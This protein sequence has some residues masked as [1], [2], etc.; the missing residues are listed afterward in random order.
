MSAKSFPQMLK[1][2]KPFIAVIVLQFGYAGMSIIFKFALNQGI[3][4]HVLV[5]YRHAVATAVVAP[6]ALVLERKTRPK[7]TTSVFTKIML[8]GLLEPVIDQNLCYTGL[9]FTTATVSAAMSNVLP[10][11]VFILAWILRLEKVNIGRIHSQAKIL[12][13]IVTVGGAMF[14]TLYNGSMLNLPWAKPANHNDSTQATNNQSSI[15]GAVMISAGCVTWSSFIILQAITL[16]SYPAELSLTTFICLSGAIQSSVV[17]LALEWG[18]PAAWSISSS[19]MLFASLYSG[20]IC[21]GFSIYIQG[22]VMKVKGPV[23][24]TAFNPLS[25]VIVAILSSFILSEIMYLGRV[26]GALFIVL[27]LYM[28][29]WGKSKDKPP[30]DQ[31][32]NKDLAQEAQHIDTVMDEK[33]KELLSI[34]TVR[35]KS[36]D[37]AVYNN[38]N[39]V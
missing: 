16:K 12:G 32:S 18:N 14:M 9:K 30:T 38:I 10:A 4:P 7:M 17:A 28:V 27:G 23:F 34:D 39:I 26:I 35:G 37:E 20:I 29:L 1:A 2:A 25:M 24:V 11:F 31:F 33:C 22:L 15:K 13:T 8:L 21:S 36:G 6:F 19:S 3:S 5:A